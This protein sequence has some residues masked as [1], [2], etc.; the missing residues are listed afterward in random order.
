MRRWADTLGNALFIL[1]AVNFVA[2]FVSYLVL[3]GDATRG[4]VEDGRYYL[5]RKGKYTEVSR[6]V[7]LYSRAHV[8][9]VCITHP[10]ALF[11]GGALLSSAERGKKS[12]RNRSRRSSRG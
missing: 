10:L 5:G 1:A 9:S 6:G 2:L 8:I 11:V 4:K 7:W 3:G 12:P